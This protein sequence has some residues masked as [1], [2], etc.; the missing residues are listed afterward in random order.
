MTLS[1]TGRI[2]NT[3]I[4]SVWN[5]GPGGN[6]HG[7]RSRRV[8]ELIASWK[9]IS[10]SMDAGGGD[11]FAG[12]CRA[13][14]PEFEIPRHVGEIISAMEAA[15]R[16]DVLRLMV[17]M[18][19]R[20][21]K[22]TVV[23]ELFPAWYL[24]KNPRGQVIHAG[25]GTEFISEFGRRVRDRMESAPHAA[26]FPR[27]KVSRDSRAVSQFATTSGGTYFAVGA[28]AGVTGRGG[29]VIIVD[30][31]IPG[32]EEADSELQREKL[33]AW[34]TNDLVTRKTRVAG[35]VP[36]IILVQTRWHEDDLAGRLLAAQEE[37]AD[38]WTVLHYPALSEDGKALWP[39]RYPVED[40]EETRRAVGQRVWQSLYQGNP[41]PD[42]GT[43]F[44]REWIVRAEPPP[45]DEM[46]FY[47]ASDYALSEKEGADF[48]VHVVV[49]VDRSERLWLIDVWKKRASTGEWVSNAVRLMKRW[50][51][52]AWG[53]E[54]GV[55]L[56]TVAPFLVKA[57]R[58]QG[59]WCQRHQ[60]ASVGD[61]E[62]RARS[63][64]GMMES[65]GLYIPNHAAWA[66]DVE[67][68]LTNFPA[69]KHDDVVDAL[70]IIG[71]M[72]LAMRSKPEP[73]KKETQAGVTWNHL[74]AAAAKRG[75]IHAIE[76]DERV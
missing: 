52:A 72:L 40:L 41:T 16:G 45:F 15:E 42:S 51:P 13:T 36:A 38:Q 75:E 27:S 68:E 67:T 58:E 53:E 20:H 50:K 3:R 29:S 1:R 33:W 39:E 5:A 74:L 48:T 64:Q 55:I 73:A 61:K 14:Y 37:G 70:S 4:G 47:G 11:S 65:R 34:Y 71:R 66:A 43:Y 59:V 21:G 62:S 31:P 2:P 32:R 24:G 9:S 22:S 49:G 44:Q 76:I 19:P 28:G 8:E 63:I 54:K 23:S 7:R 46:R 57:M 30:D 18:P 60:L 69:G 25:Y 26:I 35:K 12:Y 6:R 10:L 17:V 56:K